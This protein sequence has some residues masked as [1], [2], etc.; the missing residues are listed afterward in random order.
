MLEAEVLYLSQED[1]KAANVS[2]SEVCDAVEAAFKDQGNGLATMPAKSRLSPDA[3]RYYSAMPAVLPGLG[4]ASVKWNAIFSGNPARG[5]PFVTGLLILNDDETGLPISVMDA[6]WITAKRTGAASAVTARHLLA[7]QPERVG[8]YGCGVQGRTHA[9]ALRAV[10]P[11]MRA[12]QAYDPSPPALAS[13]VAE[14]ER[15]QGIQVVP[16]STPREAIS[17][18]QLVITA[19]PTTVRSE[20]LERD[21]LEPGQVIVSIDYDCYWTPGALGR[22]NAVFTDDLAQFE[23]SRE[24]GGYYR[25]LHAT[26]REL[27][28][29]LAGHCEGRTGPEQVIAAFN[30]GIA[31]EDAATAHLVY[32]AATSSGIGT[33]LPL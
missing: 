14:V 18:C 26:P 30:S 24:Y 19:T 32:R 5:L 8:I 13:Y 4:I 20:V 9:E 11:S 12:I 16:A 25:H 23:K 17:G 1:V 33:R 3:S 6:N 28:K 31:V 15:A 10:F 2:M 22:L 7:G 29:L 21:W 27:P